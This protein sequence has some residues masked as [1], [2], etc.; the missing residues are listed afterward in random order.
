MI[1]RPI[2]F[3]SILCGSIAFAVDEPLKNIKVPEGFDLNLFANQPDLGYP[4]SVSAAP[5]GSSVFVAVDENG[6]LDAKADR[7]RVV[8]CID[9]DGDGK[10]DKFNVFAKMDSPRGVIWEPRGKGGV[11]YVMHPPNLTAYYDEDGS[12]VAQRSEELITGLGFDLKFRGADHTTNGCRLGIDGWIYVAVGDYGAIKAEGRDGNS[13]HMKGGGV[14]RVR[15][16]GTGL[17]FVSRGQRNIY[18]VAVSPTLDLFTRDNTNDGDGWNDRLSHVV[19]GANYGYPS[20]YQNFKGEF[21]DAMVDYGGGSPCGSI[22]IDEPGFP[23][24][25]GHGLF[26][27]EWGR[28]YVYRHALKADGATWK[29]DA[30]EFVKITRPTDMDV[31]GMGHVYITSWE[32]ATF[33]YV[34]PSA[35]YVIRVSGKENKPAP[36]PDLLA[37]TGVQLVQTLNSPSATWR[38]AAQR[39]LLHRSA[40]K[41][42]GVSEALAGLANSTAPINSRVAAIFTL[43][44][45]DGA[46]S[47]DALLAMTKNDELREYALKALADDQ[48]LAAKLPAQPFVSALEDANPRV[49]LQAVTGIGRLKKL[50]EAG[51]LLPLTADKDP[52]VSHIAIRSL[53]ALKAVDACLGALDSADEKAKPGALRALFAIYDTK[54]VDGL[55]SR[56]A[57]V[58]EPQLRQ[59]ILNALCRLDQRESPYE[60]NKWWGTRPDNSGPLYKGERWEGSDKV[61]GALKAELDTARDED[62]RWLV[63][64]MYRTKVNFPGLVELMLAKAGSDSASKLTAVEGMFSPK[65]ELPNEA[66]RALVAVAANEKENPEM[67]ARSLRLLQRSYEHGAAFDSVITAF[68]SFAGRDPGNP[69][70]TAAYEN[71]TR[72]AKNAGKVG[73]LAKLVEGSDAARRLL[74][75]TILVNVATNNLI[76][77]KE[78][79]GAEKAVAKSWAKPELAASL[80]GVIARTKAKAYAEDV[81]VQLKSPDN[82]VAEAA[83]FAYQSLGLNNTETPAQLIAQMKFE[84]VSDA[85]QKGGSAAQ[86]KDLFLRQGCIACHT[87]SPDEPAKGPMLAGIATRYTRKELCE[88]IIKP[89]A[90]IA[91]GFE[92]QWFDTKK[93][94]HIEG[95]VTREGGDSLDVGNITGQVVKLEVGDIKARGKRDTSM[96]PEGLVNTISPAELASILAYLESLKAR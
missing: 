46:Q 34:G 48:R 25:W 91:Q 63:S 78:K 62:A 3:A 66:F 82:A 49:R 18:D 65:N 28:S 50:D 36:A 73:D 93:G 56:L 39:E 72:D 85:V 71:F 14:V 47:F 12:G 84:E 52:V 53:S 83:L 45:L 41:Q 92:S 96:M 29:D 74:A 1:Y 89:S 30:R 23:G 51:A 61:E 11:L 59:G 4:T 70:L 8:R 17:E 16:D 90:K 10:A 87:T 37:L 54:V 33:T 7:G 9:T 88:S 55:I 6:S 69:A 27:V 31:D 79:E 32:G 77:G 13:L 64:N 38:L 76:K 26:T 5:D 43:A 57:T 80:L 94:E 20:L 68:A 60:M 22:F 75:Q 67:R 42:E 44:Q 58:K 24:E 35:G 95:F 86:G 40:L 81:R 15:T 21:I 19:P 2:F